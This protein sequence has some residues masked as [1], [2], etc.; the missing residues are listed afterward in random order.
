MAEHNG[1]QEEECQKKSRDLNFD[2]SCP[3]C[4]QVD[5][6]AVRVQVQSSCSAILVLARLGS[7]RIK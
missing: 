4:G 1:F 2:K 6:A 5:H 7:P 3:T